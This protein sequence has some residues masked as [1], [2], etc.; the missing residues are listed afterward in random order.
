MQGWWKEGFAL[1]Q[2]AAAGAVGGEGGHM[3]RGQLLRDGQWAGPFKGEF[4]GPYAERG[5]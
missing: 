3:P 4:G 5:R 2:R 1:F